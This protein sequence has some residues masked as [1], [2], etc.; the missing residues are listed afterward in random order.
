VLAF[1]K[2]HLHLKRSYETQTLK[3]LENVAQGKSFPSI[4]TFFTC[5]QKLIQD[6][7]QRTYNVTLRDTLV[8]TL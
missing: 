7:R 4:T 3:F 2:Q 8:Q 1:T 6:S 5:Q